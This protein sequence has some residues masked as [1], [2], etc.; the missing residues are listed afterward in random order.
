MFSIENCAG[1]FGS[2]YCHFLD[3]RIATE[4]LAFLLRELNDVPI[5]QLYHCCLQHLTG[6]AR[7]IGTRMNERPW[8][9]SSIRYFSCG[10]L[11]VSPFP[12]QSSTKIIQM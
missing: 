3:H 1:L 5:W 4:V 12:I 11:E 6:I 9:T 2:E 10:S 7:K 8:P